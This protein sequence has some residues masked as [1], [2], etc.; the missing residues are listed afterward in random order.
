MEDLVTGYATGSLEEVLAGFAGLRCFVTGHNGFV[1]S[2]LCHL[3]TAAGAEVTGLSLEPEPGGLGAALG[4]LEGLASI[5]GD[6][7]D[8]DGL[9]RALEASG[10]EVVVHLAA[11]ALVLP[12]YAD[13]LATFATNVTGTANLLD[14]VRATPSVRACLVVTSDKCYALSPAAHTEEDPLGGED[15]YSASKAAAE[16]VTH[17]FRASFAPASGAVATAR[18]GN[19]V[20]GGDVA[21]DRI[22][23]DWARSLRA[24]LPLTLR[25]PEAVRPWQHVLDAAAGYLR[26]LAALLEQRAAF[27][28]AWNFGPPAT[29]AATVGEFA[30]L[31][32][33]AC[34][35]RGL[36]VPAPTAASPRKGPFERAV[37][38]LDSTKAVRRLGWQPVLDLPA[39]AAWTVEWYAAS[40]RGGFDPVAATRSQVDRYVAL[41]RSRAGAPA[42]DRP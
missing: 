19:I 18:A 17:A 41:E 10:A 4:G 33:E 12:S 5:V 6:V 25:H 26:L 11:Q 32:V 38:T 42:G 1:G 35:A 29:A 16:L 24:G 30:A 21:A 40:L 36:D 27:A 22:V 37:L 2:W 28:E 14:A 34:R 31:L 39:T 23:P 9:G 15:P 3:L 8:R 13:P 20:G 7:R